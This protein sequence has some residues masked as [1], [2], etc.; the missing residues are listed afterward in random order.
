MTQYGEQVM[1]ISDMVRKFNLKQGNVKGTSFIRTMEFASWAWKELFRNSIWEIKTVVLEVD[2][3]NHTITI[4]DGCERLINI[5]V[6]D[7]YG[8]Q[9]P[10]TYN[11]N[12]NTVSMLCQKNKCSCSN[13]H[14]EG[15]LCGA[16]DNITAVVEGVEINGETYQQTTW[17]RGNGCTIE[18]E[19]HVPVWDQTL[20]DDEGGVTYITNRQW[21][22]DIEVSDKGCILPTR[23]NIAALETYC[24]FNGA[25]LN[26]GYTNF[27]AGWV[28]PFRSLAPAPYNFFGQWNWN[29]QSRSIIHIF[30]SRRNNAVYAN[31]P[32]RQQTDCGREEND[33]HKVILSYQTA[34]V[35]PGQE[36][37][38]PDYAEMA[39]SAGILY[40]QAYFNPKDGDRN[41]T[42]L[43]GFRIHKRALDRYL[44][45][46][47]INDIGKI[48]TQPRP[49]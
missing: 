13:C 32:D 38:I 44:N 35:Y 14:G 4:P 10:L 26:N 47:K 3:K 16:M 22:C 8:K 11:P 17:M 20:N 18:K 28:N 36:I 12:L 39:V 30:R 40:Q 23:P 21:I 5:S 27:G 9:Q 33:I 24:G 37:L 46:I 15:T 49:W 48:Q 31:C 29:A 1:Y 6:I 25:C 45:P 42:M 34:G 41:R 2:R 7:R 43:A 19:E